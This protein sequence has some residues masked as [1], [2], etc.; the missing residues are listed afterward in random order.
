MTSSVRSLPTLGALLVLFGAPASAAETKIH[1]V[2][3]NYYERVR[4][5]YAAGLVNEEMNVVLSGKNQVSES[6]TSSN[7]AASQ[8]W[9]TSASLGGGRWRVTGPNRVERVLNEPQH[10]RTDVIEVHG[11]NCVATSKFV[12]KPGF[13]EYDIYSIMLRARAIYKQARMES[14]ECEISTN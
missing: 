14:S 1:V 12:L 4:P 3:H 5:G 10:T 7:H 13:S 8:S 2:F 6:F 11:S 9:S